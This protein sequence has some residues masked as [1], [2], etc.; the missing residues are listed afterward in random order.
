MARL[1]T[2]V[3]VVNENIVNRAAN[4]NSLKHF[5]GTVIEDEVNGEE[6]STKVNGKV[7]DTNLNNGEQSLKASGNMVN[8]DLKKDL[9]HDISIERVNEDIKSNVEQ[10]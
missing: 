7:G 9:K 5:S 3:A 6:S 1:E 10:D 4:G 2:N 8:G